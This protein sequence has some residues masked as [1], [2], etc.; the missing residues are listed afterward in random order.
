MTEPITAQEAIEKA[1]AWGAPAPL[2]PLHLSYEVCE[3]PE[4]VE[5][6]IRQTLASEYK[7]YKELLAP[8]HDR[9][10]SIAGFGPSLKKTWERLS[11]DIWACNGAHNWLIERGVIPKY[12]MFWDAAEIVS[13]FVTPHEDVTYIV[14]SRCHRSVFEA[15]EGHDVYV[16]HAAGDKDIEAMLEEFRKYEP[17]CSHGSASVT[18]SML[19]ASNLG[20]RKMK[21]F[22]ADSSYDGE[23]THAKESLVPEQALEIWMNGRRFQSTSW[24]AGQV[25]D[26]KLIGPALNMQGIEMEF[27][28]DG[29]LQEC[30]RING[31]VV[32]PYY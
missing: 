5:R 30:A 26:F 7:S 18:T 32:H 3:V 4:N 11:D 12:A 16:F 25:E 14:A 13:N 19:V 6:N 2:A 8:A 22:G 17:M 24:L 10:L 1:R 20:Y 27:F 28:G 31:Y 23:F 21:I 29:L 15:L 9:V